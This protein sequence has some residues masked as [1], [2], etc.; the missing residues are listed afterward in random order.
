[1]KWDVILCS[2]GEL[3]NSFIWLKFRLF[4]T[5][6]TEGRADDS[7][8]S[9]QVAIFLAWSFDPLQITI[10]SQERFP[11]ATVYF[12][13]YFFFCLQTRVRWNMIYVVFF[14]RF[15]CSAVIRLCRDKLSYLGLCACAPLFGK[16][17]FAPSPILLQDFYFIIINLFIIVII[18]NKWKICL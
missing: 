17:S 1:M 6:Q 9:L 8:Q 3:F 4:S 16:Q 11:K 18:Y 13:Y 5:Q 10:S 12:F 15:Y 14:F 7:V 2:L